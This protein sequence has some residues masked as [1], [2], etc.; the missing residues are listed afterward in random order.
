MHQLIFSSFTLHHDGD[1]DGCMFLN[2]P[3][4]LK[5]SIIVTRLMLELELKAQRDKDVIVLRAPSAQ[6]HNRFEVTV[7]QDRNLFKAGNW[8]EL[9]VQVAR[10]DLERIVLRYRTEKIRKLAERIDVPDQPLSQSLF[11]LD[12]M[13]RELEQLSAVPV[14]A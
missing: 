3:G 12:S 13:I 4:E 7:E 6:A 2:P 11:V 14:P 8:K 10:V 9:T 5:Q 1:F